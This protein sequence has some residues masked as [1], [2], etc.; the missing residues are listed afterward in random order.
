MRKYHKWTAESR[1]T[2]E[3]LLKEGY[4]VP[5]IANIMSISA[6]TVY[7]EIEKGVSEQEYREKRYIKY[8]ADKA[9]ETSIMKLKGEIN[10]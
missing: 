2:L 10:D 1:K 6:M 8:T 5:Q 3:A 9:I 4:K 7:K